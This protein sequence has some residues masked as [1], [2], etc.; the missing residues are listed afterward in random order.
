MEKPQ[1][2]YSFYDTLWRIRPLLITIESRS[3]VKFM[4]KAPDGT[5]GTNMFSGTIEANEGNQNDIE[6]PVFIPAMQKAFFT[7]HFGDADLPSKNPAESDSDFHE[8]LRAYLDKT[9]SISGLVLF[10]D[11]NHYQIELPKWA[12]QRPP[13][14]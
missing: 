11:T 14:K 9:Y 10:D 5:V 12:S 2:R 13:G 4:F 3:A 6:L 8:R 1:F 7:C